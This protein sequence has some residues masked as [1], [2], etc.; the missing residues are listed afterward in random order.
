VFNAQDATFDEFKLE[1]VNAN[2]STTVKTLAQAGIAAID[3][4]GDATHIALPDGSLITGQTSFTKTNGLTGTVA[5]TTLSFEADGHKVTQEVSFDA[6]NSR[7]VA[8]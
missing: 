7:I 4:T 5:N 2:G 1:V 8:T 6:A 3:L